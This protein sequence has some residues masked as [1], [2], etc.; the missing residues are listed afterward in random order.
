MQGDIEMI[1]RAW[2]RLVLPARKQHERRA[3]PSFR[4]SRLHRLRLE[5]LE[6]RRLFAPVVT[7]L[8]ISSAVIDEDGSITVDGTFTNP[9][10]GGTHTVTFDWG[11]NSIQ[12]QLTLAPGVRT[13]ST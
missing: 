7:G 4:A 10:V 9:G 3:N 11:N 6:D 8:S 1:I 12:T 5:Q 13:F 2:Q